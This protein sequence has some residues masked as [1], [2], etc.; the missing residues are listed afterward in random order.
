MFQPITALFD[1]CVLYSTPIRDI[2]MELGITGLYHAK[3]TE[4]IH[5]EWMDNLMVNR[6]DLPFEKLERTK[7]LMD[8]SIPDCLV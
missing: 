8:Q 4:Q 1:S 5:K 3:W 7:T 2:I 6:P